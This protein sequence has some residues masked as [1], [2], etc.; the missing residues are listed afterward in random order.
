MCN[1]RNANV[2]PAIGACVLILGGYG[3][4][5]PAVGATAAAG[6]GNAAVWSLDKQTSKIEFSSKFMTIPFGGSFKSWDAQ[7]AFDPNALSASK[8]SVNINLASAVT[9]H[10]TRDEALPS[11]EWFDTKKFPRAT[12]V[13]KRFKSLGDNRYEA[14]A[15]LAIHGVTKE[16]TLPFTLTITG[17]RASLK[18]ALTIQRNAFNVG[19][20][21]FEDTESVP[22]AVG[23]SLTVNARRTP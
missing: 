1:M 13:T 3:Q 21:Y 23:I 20:G 15:D 2:L 12:F 10:P 22:Y 17:D 11:S 5:S 14:V 16:V 7:I 18:G 8:V 4:V 9:G 19:T 6:P